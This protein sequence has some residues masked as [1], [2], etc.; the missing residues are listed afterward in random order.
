M[1]LITEYWQQLTAFVMLVY[2]LSMMRVEIGVLKQ[3]VAGFLNLDFIQQTKLP[4]IQFSTGFA[5]LFIPF[6]NPRVCRE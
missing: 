5:P 6:M 2:I 4:V 1:D 3:K